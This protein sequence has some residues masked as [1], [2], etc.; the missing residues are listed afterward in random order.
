M[1]KITSLPLR[2][3]CGAR[4]WVF[5]RDGWKRFVEISKLPEMKISKTIG[6]IVSIML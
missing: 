1:K 2:L 4:K 3:Y 5:S 6:F